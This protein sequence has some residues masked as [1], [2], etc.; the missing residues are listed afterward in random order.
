MKPTPYDG[1]TTSGIQPRKHMTT[2]GKCNTSDLMKP[3]R[4]PKLEWAS[5]THTTPYIAKKIRKVTGIINYILHT[6]PTK[7]TQQALTL[8]AGVIRR[9]CSMQA[10]KSVS[11]WL[12]GV[13]CIKQNTTLRSLCILPK[14][15]IIDCALSVEI[16]SRSSR[17]HLNNNNGSTSNQTR[18]TLL[19]QFKYGPGYHSMRSRFVYSREGG[20]GGVMASELTQGVGRELIEWWYSPLRHTTTGSLHMKTYLLDVNHQ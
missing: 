7:Y 18:L 15:H 13:A 8:V 5:S 1:T 14:A 17:I 11:C 19:T 16:K 9:V 6:L 4:P 2:M 3:F 12:E 10:S 20:G